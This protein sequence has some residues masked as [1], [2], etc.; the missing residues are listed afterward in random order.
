MVEETQGFDP[1]SKE[2]KDTDFARIAASKGLL[3]MFKESS[4]RLSNR[5]IRYERKADLSIETESKLTN[6][7]TLYHN[8]LGDIKKQGGSDRHR[9]AATE[10]KVQLNQQRTNK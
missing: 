5:A 10:A 6:Y 8:V 9:R 3:D 4:V 2:I 7:E 1:L